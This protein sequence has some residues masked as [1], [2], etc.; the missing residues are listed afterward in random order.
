[1]HLIKV[2]DNKIVDIINNNIWT[3]YMHGDEPRIDSCIPEYWAAIGQS[4]VDTLW[5]YLLSRCE[6]V[7][8]ETAKPEPARKYTPL[9]NPV[10]GETVYYV[11]DLMKNIES[12]WTVVSVN[13]DK[14]FWVEHGSDR[15]LHYDDTL[16][17]RIPF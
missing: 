15:R 16:F 7:A 14:G 4:E 5:T 1:M 13:E 11:S 8:K 12:P 3:K 2:S 6:N 9:E 17:A 10:V